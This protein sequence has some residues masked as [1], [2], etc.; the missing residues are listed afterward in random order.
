MYQVLRQVIL[1]LD[2][3]SFATRAVL[4]NDAASATTGH[5][6]QALNRSMPTSRN[7]YAA[8][9]EDTLDGVGSGCNE[10]VC[11]RPHCAC[12]S[13]KPPAGL[14]PDQ[15]P[16]FVTMTFDD[17]VTETNMA[18]YRELLEGHRRKNKKNGCGIAATFFVSH[19]Y[20]DYTL[21]NELHSL[22]NEIAVHSISRRANWSYWQIIN[23]TQW[24]REVLDQKRMMQEFANVPAA[25]VTGFMGPFLYTGGDEG[26]RML[27]RN[28]RYDCTLVHPR[29]R[30]TSENPTF[31][32]TMD[33]GFRHRCHV[34]PCPKDTYK[35]LWVVPVNEFFREF[36]GQQ[37]PC[38]KP[39]ACVPQPTTANDT[40]EYF[41]SNFQDFYT[42]NRAPFPLFL[43]EGYLQHPERKQGYLQFI[44][45]LLQKDNVY[46]VTVSEVLRFMQD[47]KPL[48]TY[49][50]HSCPRRNPIK[51]NTCLLRTKCGYEKTSLG[52]ERYMATC[53]RC[54]KSYP[55]VGN[56]M[57]D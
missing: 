21:V 37:R 38:A 48:G 49:T 6:V 5:I 46:L 54:P 20:T 11:L 4:E 24:E 2:V 53:S 18:F 50:Q 32:Y 56:P 43:H 26:F 52:S 55:W 10:A 22:D 1:F 35:G 47:P 29:K 27:Q 23:S 15:M 45:W 14:R 8:A 28:F 51:R 25:E 33:Y 57:G 39:D 19:E 17:A 30:R 31:P 16:Q 9:A 42:T 44:D 40:F 34:S 12:A 41:R 36:S 7:T 13:D 3:L